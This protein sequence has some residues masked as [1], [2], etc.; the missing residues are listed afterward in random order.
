MIAAQYTANAVPDGHTEVIADLAITAIISA[1][2]DKPP[3]DLLR[4]FVPVSLVGTTPFFLAVSSDLGVSTLPEF[5]ALAK[6]R[7]GKPLYGSSGPGSVHHLATE[8]LKS[9]LGVD[10]VHVPYKSSGLSTPALLA[11]DVQVLFTALGPVLPHVKSGKVRL[12]A[13]A[14]PARAPQSPDVPAFPELGVKDLLLVPSLHALVPAGTPRAVVA[15]L[16][17]A[18]RRTMQAPAALKRLET[19]GIDA[20]GSTPD[21]SAQIKAARVFYTRA[22]KLSG[23]RPTN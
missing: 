23:A 17:S 1:L 21:E 12:L 10:L 9:L 15:K 5:V 14:S 20:V 22:V 2:S 11:G 6:S 8:T 7:P 18:N 13:E 4:D 16:S 19:L 3:F